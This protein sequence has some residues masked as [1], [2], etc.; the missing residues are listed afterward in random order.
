ML[1]IELFKK[2]CSNN[3]NAAAEALVDFANTIKWFLKLKT[4]KLTRLENFNTQ[5][6]EDVIQDVLIDFFT[7]KRIYLCSKK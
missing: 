4:S 1:E 6:E 7:K 2:F 5:D 3:D